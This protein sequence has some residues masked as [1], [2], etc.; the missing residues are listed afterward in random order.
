MRSPRVLVGTAAWALPR[1]HRRRFP[2]A[3]SNLERYAARLNCTE[4]NA[5]FY[6]PHKPAT[7]AGWAESVPGDFRFSVKTPQEITHDLRLK[8]A[9]KPLASFLKGIAPLGRKLGCLLVQ[10]PPSLVFEKAVTA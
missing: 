1:A 3:G 10:L 7:Y 5:S 8:G 4:I 6:R 2:A 9:G